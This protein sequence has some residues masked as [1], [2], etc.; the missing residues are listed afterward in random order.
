MR[1]ALQQQSEKLQ[2]ALSEAEEAEAYK[3][4]VGQKLSN[5]RPKLNAPR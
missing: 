1:T 2:E 4:A 3:Q 5:K